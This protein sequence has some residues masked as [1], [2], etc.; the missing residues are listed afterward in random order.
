MFWTI[1]KNKEM[2][3]SNGLRKKIVPVL[4]RT[5]ES[6]PIDGN[7]YVWINGNSISVFG[8]EIGVIGKEDE[9]VDANNFMEDDGEARQG[10]LSGVD[11]D[12]DQNLTNADNDG[13]RIVANYYTQL[14]SKSIKIPFRLKPVSNKI[15]NEKHK[16]VS[17][18]ARK[19]PMKNIR[20]MDTF[21]SL[22]DGF[23]NLNRYLKDVEYPFPLNDEEAATLVESK[24]LDQQRRKNLD[25]NLK[26]L[27]E[28]IPKTAH[29]IRR[30]GIEP[31]PQVDSEDQLQK[32]HDDS[33]R[34]YQSYGEAQ[35][36]YE[37]AKKAVKGN[38]SKSAR[39]AFKAAT[40]AMKATKA[41]FNAKSKAF[42]T[43]AQ[44]QINVDHLLIDKMINR[45]EEL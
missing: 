1:N 39:S 26:M 4:K 6:F 10:L 22:L 27:N 9:E 45:L 13:K 34:A 24:K 14:H 37:E 43:A 36:R 32:L 31:Y 40:S 8:K 29:D 15:R 3:E 35:K 2:L 38:S 17:G 33:E 5:I 21:L 30:Q 28:A 23:E 7:G 20:W 41:V 11:E 12:M 18:K 25:D 44:N 16:Q 19:G 42:S